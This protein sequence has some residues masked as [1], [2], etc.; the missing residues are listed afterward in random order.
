[1]EAVIGVLCLLVLPFVGIGAGFWLMHQRIGQLQKRFSEVERRLTQIEMAPL[2]AAA[3]AV[4]ASTSI[5]SS[6][7]ETLLPSTLAAP[8]LPT[9]L[10]PGIS[11]PPPLLAQPDEA[12]SSATSRPQTLPS[13]TSIPVTQPPA[14]PARERHTA[15]ATLARMPLIDRFLRMHLLVQI[16]LVVLLIGVALL[17]RYAVDQGWL[18]IELRHLGAAAG[19]AALGVAGWFACKKQRGYGLAL[20]GGGLAILYL[21]T[22]SAYAIYALLPASV[23]FGFFALLSAFGVVLAL[24]Q[25]AR[26]LA[27]VA[28]VGAFAAPLLAADGGGNYAGLLGYYAVVTVTALT[29]AVRKGWQGLALL[30]LPGVYGVGILNSAASFTPDDYAGTLAFVAA[31]F[32]LFLAAS[33]LLAQ[34]P[35]AERRVLDL[36]VAVLNPVAALV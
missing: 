26:L 8:P 1:M 17:L 10:T 24:L 18:S 5:G 19:G 7:V 16:G 31:F 9:T 23:A 2:Q 30:S 33:L 13:A 34:G 15:A 32:A 11:Q 25:D 20:Q 22:F 21:T 28:M 14:T 12:P 4:D 6:G 35:S 29:L 36:V 3:S 27:Y